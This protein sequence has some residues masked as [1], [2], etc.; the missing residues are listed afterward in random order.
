MEPHE[1]KTAVVA[2][3]DRR[4]EA[5]F[6]QGFLTDAGIQSVVLADDAGGADLGLAFTRRVP[7]LVRAEDEDRAR[8][9]LTDA[10]VLPDEDENG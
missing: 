1:T 2:S 7:L 6:A 8:Q 10:G 4:H 9:V 5:E 3:F